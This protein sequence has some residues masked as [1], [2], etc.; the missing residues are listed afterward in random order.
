MPTV[1]FCD[2]R[3]VVGARQG[4]SRRPDASAKDR[5]VVESTLTEK[6]TPLNT[7]H[8]QGGA[9]PSVTDLW[10]VINTGNRPSARQEL[11]NF[12]V[13]KT[14]ASPATLSGDVGTSSTSMS[15]SQ[16]PLSG[17]RPEHR[18]SAAWREGASK[19]I[20]KRFRVSPSAGQPS[21]SL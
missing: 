1:I 21:A 17:G 13:I 16:S 10:H 5:I 3:S 20:P 12:A 9:G 15:S 6:R 2:E 18:S 11:Q 14:T 7:L 8:A 19:S 4:S